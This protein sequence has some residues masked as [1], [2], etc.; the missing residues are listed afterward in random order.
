MDDQIRDMYKTIGYCGTRG[1]EE[2]GT[3]WFTDGTT[4]WTTECSTKMLNEEHSSNPLAEIYREQMQIERER[5]GN[6]Y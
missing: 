4:G 2:V 3:T 6:S 5:R 1:I